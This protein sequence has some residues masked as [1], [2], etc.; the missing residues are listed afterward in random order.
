M[1]NYYVDKKEFFE[2]I[3]EYQKLCKEAKKKKLPKPK[4]SDY[5]G[6]CIMLIAKNLANSPKF[7]KY[8]WKDEMIEDAIENCIMYF[9]NFDKRVSKNPFAY[10]TQICWYAFV[11]RIQKEKKQ[12]Y[13]KY[14]IAQQFGVLEELSGGDDED[15]QGRKVE[16]YENLEEFITKYEEA[17]DKKVKK[18]AKKA[19]RLEEFME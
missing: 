1:T 14:K 10:Y 6:N 15:G 7:Y 3:L 2:K 8:T 4:I 5:L 13:T 12:Q 18:P 17:K 11:R 9:D 16:L 19:S